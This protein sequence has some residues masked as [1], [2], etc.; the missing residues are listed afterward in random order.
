M[1]TEDQTRQ[2]KQRAGIKDIYLEGN[3]TTGSSLWTFHIHVGTR[4]AKWQF[5]YRREVGYVGTKMAAPHSRST[6]HQDDDMTLG[7]LTE[8][9]SDGLGIDVFRETA[10]CNKF[11]T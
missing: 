5:N 4:D 6:Q 1:E 10:S 7:V 9:R 2:I 11:S 3:Y 8:G